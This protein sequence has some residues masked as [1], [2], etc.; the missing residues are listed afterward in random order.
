MTLKS[1]LISLIFFLSLPVGL[2]QA[3]EDDAFFVDLVANSYVEPFR[4]GD[5]DRWIRAFDKEAIAMHNRRPIDRGR[6]A[7]ETFGRAV[8]QHFRLQEYQVEVTDIR[9][10]AQWVYT[11]GSYTTHFISRDDG[12]APFGREQGK[13]LLL[14]ERKADGDWKIIL[15]TGNSDQ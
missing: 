13:F 4:A 5:I 8:H 9:R 7:I 2:V 1:H 3:Q 10:S 15:D 11:V 14:W 6:E 12:S